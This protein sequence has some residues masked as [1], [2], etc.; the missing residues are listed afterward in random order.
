MTNMPTQP[1]IVIRDSLEH[2]SPATDALAGAVLAIGN[3]EGVHRGHRALI[4]AARA[5]ARFSGPMSRSSG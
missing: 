5:R 2:S 3:F 1:F 4:G